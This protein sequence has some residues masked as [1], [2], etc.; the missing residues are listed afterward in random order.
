M[1]QEMLQ[2]KKQ[3]RS[4]KLILKRLLREETLTSVAAAQSSTTAIATANETS[5][6]VN[7]V[8]RL[9][10]EIEMAAGTVAV[11]ATATPATSATATTAT[12]RTTRTTTTTRIADT[13]VCFDGR[14]GH[15]CTEE[16]LV[17]ETISQA[18]QEVIK[19]MHLKLK[20]G[21]VGS[22]LSSIALLP[23]NVTMT[24]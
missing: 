13:T 5:S 22:Q 15:R 11:A 3:R 4:K 20:L 1:V 8:V 17:E 12:T 10:S 23:Q 18:L 7:A 21:Y 2:T 14:F 19:K 9:T 6:T 16:V 24:I